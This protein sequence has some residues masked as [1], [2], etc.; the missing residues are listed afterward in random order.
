MAS[1]TVDVSL[2]TL[3]KVIPSNPSKAVEHQSPRGA[4]TLLKVLS[5]V[6]LRDLKATQGGEGGRKGWKKSV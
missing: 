2:C 5:S 6:A 3:S 1:K 4:N